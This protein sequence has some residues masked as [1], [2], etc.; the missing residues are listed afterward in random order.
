[1][2]YW[3]CKCICIHQQQWEPITIIWPHAFV[4]EISFTNLLLHGKGGCI[5]WII[6]DTFK[7][8]IKNSCYGLK[9]IEPIIYSS[10]WELDNYW[11]ENIHTL[12][13]HRLWTELPQAIWSFKRKTEM[14]CIKRF[15]RGDKIT[16]IEIFSLSYEIKFWILSRVLVSL[17]LRYSSV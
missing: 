17:F 8:F 5:L 2:L 3:H 11:A 16:Y 7:T 15:R 10:I 13:E 14:S 12:L 9:K 1:M 6:S 4:W